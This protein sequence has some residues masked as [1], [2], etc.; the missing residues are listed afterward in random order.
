[1]RRPGA[2]R[3]AAIPLYWPC[4]SSCCCWLSTA[5]RQRRQLPRRQPLHQ[6]PCLLFTLAASAC[7]P[8]CCRCSECCGCRRPRVPLGC[9]RHV[10]AGAGSCFIYHVDGAV[11]QAAIGNVPLRRLD[12]CSR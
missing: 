3:G 7:W 5:A 2:Q 9:R 6:A 10:Q 12:S 4:C 8:S 1:M 11:W